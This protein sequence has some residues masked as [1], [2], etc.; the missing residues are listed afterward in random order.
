M[1]RSVEGSMFRSVL[2]KPRAIA[3]AVT[4][5]NVLYVLV[6]SFVPEPRYYPGI[7]AAQ[8][9]V[10]GTLVDVALVLIAVVTR[11]WS[12][13]FIMGCFAGLMFWAATLA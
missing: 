3:V 13:A 1:V 6:V 9:F 2:K 8:L 4:V 11:A 5:A 12:A 7:L 10:Y